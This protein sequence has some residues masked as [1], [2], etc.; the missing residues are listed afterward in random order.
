[1][2]WSVDDALSAMHRQVPCLDFEYDEEL[3]EVLT[4]MNEL[5]IDTIMSCQ[6][7]NPSGV[8]RDEEAAGSNQAT[9]TNTQAHARGSQLA[10]CETDGRGGGT[11][12]G[13]S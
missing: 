4:L 8:V 7:S 12:R 5:G 9:P 13:S 10:V 2:A 6:D 11:V 1:M 3:V